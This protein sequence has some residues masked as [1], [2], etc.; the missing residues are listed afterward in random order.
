MNVR[1]IDIGSDKS[2]RVYRGN[3]FFSISI[4]HIGTKLIYR[5]LKDVEF[6]Y[7]VQDVISELGETVN[8]GYFDDYYV[9][10]I[11]LGGIFERAKKVRVEIIE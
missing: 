5:N 8:G 2:L 6:V 3:E 10:G 7:H 1:L 11:P 9:N 4:P